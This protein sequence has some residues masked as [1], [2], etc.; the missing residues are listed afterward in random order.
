MAFHLIK[1]ALEQGQTALLLTHRRMLF[2]QLDRKLQESGIHPGYR[3]AGMPDYDGDVTLAMVQTEYARAFKGD[4]EP[5]SADLVIQDECH[6]DKGKRTTEMLRYHHSQGS[7]IVGLSAT[8]IDV[9]HLYEDIAYAGFHSDLLK[10]GLH[11]PLSMYAPNE[12]DLSNLKR[13]LGK[14]REQDLTKRFATH[15]VVG[16]VA[17]S[18]KEFNPELKPTVVYG[19]SVAGSRYITDGLNDA[20]IKTAHLDGYNA[21]WDGKDI[22][23]SKSVRDDIVN[24]LL[25]SKLHAISNRFVLREGIDIPELYCVSLATRMGLVSY[26]QACGRVLRNHP[27]LDHVIIIDHGGNVRDHGVVNWDRMYDLT[28]PEHKQPATPDRLKGW[29]CPKCFHMEKKAGNCANCGHQISQPNFSVIQSDGTLKLVTLPANP[30][31]SD[32]RRRVQR[33]WDRLVFPILHKR[34][35]V[36]YRELAVRFQHKNPG[37][38]IISHRHL[39]AVR[40]HSGIVV[41]LKRAPYPQSP[42]W[43]Q[44]VFQAKRPELQ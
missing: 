15:A 40:H 30:H 39:T 32:I 19:P 36:T 12:V 2:D 10:C 7:T 13:T 38:D 44:Y 21:Y 28:V 11:L 1:T 41:H 23:S 5:V 3:A 24:A 27:S 8:P 42:E 29:R 9:G 22:K 20:G 17:S 16:C 25:T 31:L 35:K 33:E 26:I 14:Y 18:L 34:A 37:Y 4:A 43:H 6:A